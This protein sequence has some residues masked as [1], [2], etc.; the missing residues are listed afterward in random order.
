M[1]RKTMRKDLSLLLNSIMTNH[2]NWNYTQGYNDV[3]GIFLQT[4]GGG[5]NIDLTY[6]CAESAS[7]HFLRDPMVYESFDQGVIPSLKLVLRLL[8]RFD[9]EL[10]DKI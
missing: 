6:K 5:K 4:I 1:F 8:K 10:Y 2:K 7:Q 3:V 9:P